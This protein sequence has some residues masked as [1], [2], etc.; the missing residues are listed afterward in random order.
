MGTSTTAVRRA[1]QFGVLVRHPLRHARLWRTLIRARNR[2][3]LA[4]DAMAAFKYLGD[5]LSHGMS[6]DDRL[7][8]IH[9]H[10]SYLALYP[11]LARRIAGT[12]QERAWGGGVTLWQHADAEG[13]V[14]RVVLRGSEMAPMEGEGELAFHVDGKRLCTLTFVILDGTLVGAGPAPALFVGGVQ[15]AYRAREAIR[16]AARG[17]DEIAPLTML[18]IALRSLA[19]AIGIGTIA[20]TSSAVQAARGT[21]VDGRGMTHDYD[22]FWQQ[23]G[24]TLGL[25]G[26]YL[27]AVA[28]ETSPDA[29]VTGKH[30]S[31]T[32][33]RRQRRL[34]IR[35]SIRAAVTAIVEG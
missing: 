2:G 3:H 23:A 18:L 17:N 32:R 26:Y 15:G 28:A 12:P 31:R 1:R 24:G 6:Q 14:A 19:D 13:R 10:Y 20:G 22:D 29:P 5:Y 21:L 27:S 4:A 8:A 34:D 11:L 30:R 16:L 7:D 25:R 35:A 9:Y 33:R